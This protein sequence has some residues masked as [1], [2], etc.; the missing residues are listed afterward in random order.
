MIRANVGLSRKV[1][2]DYQSNGYS[3][4]IEADVAVS[5]NDTETTLAK[6]AELFHLAEEAL[7]V[8]IDRDQGDHTIGRRDE[9]SRNKNPISHERPPDNGNAAP[10]EQGQDRNA[11]NGPDAIT[12]KQAQYVLTLGKRQRLSHAQMEDK[13][14]QILRR[15]CSVYDLTKREAGQLINALAPSGNGQ[16]AAHR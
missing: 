3:I 1:T 6:V 5:A 4:N 15:R 12:N 9:L 13:I 14:E 10:T 7:N 2:R 8:E 11:T 16:P